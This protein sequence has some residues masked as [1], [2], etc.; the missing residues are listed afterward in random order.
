LP[1]GSDIPALSAVDH[2]GKTISLADLKG[3]R[4]LVYFYPKDGTP[5]C[6]T[7]ACTLRDTW[8]QFEAADIVIVGVSS[9]DAASHRAF[10]EEHDLPFSLIPDE[11]LEWPTAFGVGNLG[12]FVD[13]V[14]FLIGRDGKVA[15]VYPGVDPGVHA[16]EVLADAAGMP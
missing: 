5:G 16:Q 7:E 1:E 4:V 3:H 10:A 9:D 12:G 6:T 11:K 15:K 14:S 8:D 2:D 13:R